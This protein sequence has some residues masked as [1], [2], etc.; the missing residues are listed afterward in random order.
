M[1]PLWKTDDSVI[2]SRHN[3]TVTK[4]KE[5]YDHQLVACT[6]SLPIMHEYVKMKQEAMR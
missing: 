1:S 3:D 2:L 6:E 4:P 5:R